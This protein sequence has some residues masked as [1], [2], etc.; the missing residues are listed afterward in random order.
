MKTKITISK[1]LIVFLIFSLLSISSSFA[2]SYPPPGTSC[3]SGDLT[4]VG[5]TLS[6]GDLCNSCPTA[7][8]ITRTLTLSINN[9]TGST[10][11]SFAFWGNLEV[12]SGTTGLLVSNTLITGCNGPL[13]PNTITTLSYNTV[14]YTCGDV[15][16]ITNLYLAWTSASPGSTCPLDPTLISPKCGT[17]PTITV[18]GGV[19]GEFALTDS[20]CGSATGAIDLTPTGGTAPFT[21][22]WTATAGGAVPSGQ[23]NNQDLTGLLPGTY[24]VV[25]T[26]VNGCTITKSRTIGATTPTI[27]TFANTSDITVP[28]GGATTS[29]LSYTNN[30]T[31]SCLISGTVTS[32]LSTQTP[33]GA[34]GGTVT[35][36]WTFTDA[37]GRTITKTRTITISPATL[38]TMTAPAA[39][40]VA[41]GSLPAPT[42]LS[43]TNGLSGGCL[44]NGTSNP[45][46]F[47]TPPGAC[48]GTVTETWTAT[49]S[50]GRA[51]APV[52]RIITVSPAAL[53]TMT[54]PAATT[55]ACGSLPAPSTISFS[56][57]LSGGCLI[58]GNSNPSTFSTTPGACGGT[59]TETW[60]A[61]D[62][63]GRALAPVSR[64]ITVSPATL[65]TM[66]APAA[67][68]VACGS[69]PAPSTISFSNGLSGGCLISGNSNPSTFST[70]PGACGGTVT[71]TWTATDSCGRALAPVS[72]IIT[73]S[74]AALPTMTAPTA[75]TVACGS[76]PAPST[77]SFSNG[78]SGGCLISGTSN[79]STFSTLSS[80]CGGTITETWTATD[81]CG[82]ALAPVSRT[83]TVS[84][85]ALPTMTAPANITVA[86]G[87]I[88]A[89]ST[90]S[91][92]NG[93]S[94]SCAINGTS[95]P[96]TFTATPPTCGGTVTET[97]TATDSCGRTIASVSR[98]ITVSPAALPT[99]N[100]PSGITI[101][102]G[103]TP[104]PSTLSF[105][106]GL[107]GGCAI[108]GTS[109]PSTFTTTVPGFCNGQIVETW[110]ATDSCGRALAPVTR[111]ITVN[112]TTPPTF[113]VP[114][115]I[116][117][118]TDASCNT[119]LDPST[120]GTVTNISD[121]CDTAPTVTYSDN[122][123]FGNDNAGSIN[124]GNGNYFYFDVTGFDNLT[125]KDI[126]KIALAFETN[127]GKGR[128]EFTLVAPNGTAVILVGPYCTGGACEDAN[129][130]DQELYLPT[131][132]PNSSGYP[133]WNNNDVI[134]QDIPQ[135]FTPNGAL[136]SP[137]SITGLTSYV[138]SFENLTGP[139]NG[140]WFIFS[141]K[142]A[143]VNG[144]IN[145]NSVCLTPLNV[146][147]NNRVITRTWTVTDA[148]GNSSTANQTISIQDVT[149]PT[150]T[151]VAGS[152]DAT[153]E[154]SDAAALAS[155]QA[156]FPTATDNCDTDVTNIVKT[157]GAFVASQTCANA[158]T[159]TNTW[160][161]TD[162]CGNTSQV[163]TQTITVRDT[164]PPTWT[165]VAGTLDATI[166]CSNAAALANAQA[167]APSATDNCD[168]NV[169]YIKTSG[170]FVP[171][172]CAG[173]GSY[174]NTWVA[175]DACLNTS[176][177]FTQ[178][179][180]VQDTTA[181]TISIAAA[182][183]TVECDGL[184]NT[185]ALAAW[186]ASNGGA[187][188]SD[189]C[190]SVTWT[191]N[192]S[193]LSD[194]CGNSGSALVTFTAT[195]DCGNATTTSAT[196]T[197]QDDTAPTIN[198]QATN[199]TVE[200]DGNG[201]SAAL[202]AWLASNG[203]ASASDICSNVTWTNNFTTL[204]NGCGNS[205]SAL[206]TFTATD[207]CGN[208]TSSTATFTIRDTTAP[209]IS[210]AA[211]DATVECDGNGNSAALTAWLASNGGASA[212][213]ICSNVTW[214]NN[215]SAFTDSCG[216][217]GSASVTF[218]A[219]DDCGN[220]T[221]TSATFTIQDT[222]A[223][224]I[225]IAATDA[226][227]ECDGQGNTAALAEWLASNGG[228]S[229]SDA[230]SNVTWSNNFSAFTDG[231]GNSG[232][233]LV[234]FTA[235][236]DCGN[237]TTTSATFTI[238]DTTAPT[239]TIAA[240]DATVECDGQGNT[241]TLAEWLASNGGASASDICSNVTWSNNFSAFTD[242][243]GNSGSALV[244]FTAT[245]DCGN[246]TTTS[247]TFTIQD[248]TAP[249]ITIAATDATVECDGQGNTA[250]LA[251]WLASNGGASASDA[252]SNVIWT[253]NFSAFTDGCGNSGSALVTFT[254]TDDCGN[255]S[256]TSA[257]F[258]IQD[259]T[260][261]T[262]T[263]AA[264]D[265]TVEC[266][267][268]GNTAALE[269]W[270]SSNGGASAS[271]ACS[272]VIWT[273]NFSAFT[274]GCGNSGSA[275]V[276]FTATDD[277]G[278]ATT[279]S[280]TFTIQDTTAPTITI[281][282]TDATV[283]CDGQGNTAALEA[284]LSSNGGASAS[285]VCSNVT[286][287][288]NF[289]ALTDGC[290]NSG[291]ASV[292]FT[293]TDDCGNAVTSTATFTIQD[294]T[295]PTINIA[296]TDLAV[297]CDGSGG[298]STALAAWLASN[299]GASASDTCSNVTWTNNFGTIASDCS[300]AITVIFTAT[301]DCGNASTT[302][303]TFTVQDNIAPT[304]DIVAANATVECDGN[305]NSE[306]LAA[307]LASNGGAS[308][309]D[310]CS[311]VTW[312][313]NFTTFTDG[314][315]NSGSATVTFTA[316]DTCGN[317]ATTSATFTIQDTTAPTITIAAANAT[318]ECDGN[319]NT[320][321]LATWLASN[322]GASA[323]DTCSNVI[324]SNNFNG[325]SNGCGNTGSATVTFTATDDCGNA[326]TTSATFT[327]EDTTAPTI[328]IAAADA[329]VECDGNG[330]PEALV[331][332]LASNGGASA[333][334]TC[335]N[336]TWT[337]NFEEL[338]D[339]CGSTGSATV[340][341]TA[342]DD[343]GNTATSTAT[344][345]IQDTTAPIITIAAANATAECD[346]NGNSTALAAWLASNGGASATD[347]CSNVTWT[348]NFDGLSDGCGN[349]GSA[350]VTFTATDDCGN[351]ATTS[352]T[353][354]IEDTTA[355]TITIAAVNASAECDGN[356][357]AE[358]LAAWLASN[359][360]ASATD[361]C[362]NV[363]WTNNFDGLSDGCGN[364]GS[365]T[366][367]FTATD[368]CGNTATTS[369]TFTIEDT[370]APTITIAATNATAE[371]D[372]NGNAE[373]LAAWLASNG[374]ASATD[375]C[376]NVTWTNSF[377][378]LSDGC[379]NTG[380]ATVTFT[381]TDDCGNTATTSATFT[382]EDTTAPT[383]T[384]VATDATVE[385]DGN[386]NA[387]ALA[388]W[389]ASNGGASATDTCSNVTWTNNFSTF[390]DGCGNAGSA[391]VT[392]TAA[393]DCGNI[394]TSTATFTIQDTTAPTI[395][396]VATDATV[397]CDGNGNAEA[398]AAWLASNGGAS[399][400][401]SCSNVT[402]TN[403]FDGLSDGCGNT[404]SATVTFTATDDCGNSVTSTAT[405]T[406]QDTTAPT[407][408][409]A[410]TDATAECDGNG[411]T[412]ALAAWLA[413]NGGASASDACSNVTWTNNYEAL[414]DGCGS[415]GSATVT[416]TAT[417]DCGNSTSSTATFAIQDTTPPT[418][419]VTTVN[420]TV[421]CDGSGN[422][423]AL[424]AWLASN[425]GASAIDICSNV[426]WTNSFDGLSDGCG[427]TGSASV[428]FT[429][430]DDCGNSA[431][432]TGTFTIVDT[433]APT[434]T[435][436]AANSTVECD[437][438][439]NTAALNAWLASNGGATASDACSNVTWSNNFIALSDDCGSTGSATVIFTAT[440]GCGNSV[441]S[442]AT[443]TIQDTTAP[444]LTTEFD[445]KL[446]VT[447]AAI[448]DAPILVFTDNCSGN[449]TPV[450]N[451][452]QSPTVDNVYTIIR[453]WIA[454]DACG[455][456]SQTYTQ[457]IYVTVTNTT[458]LEIP[459]ERCNLAEFDSVDLVTLL[460]QGL[461]T[462][463]TWTNV[464]SATGLTGTVFNPFGVAIGDYIFRYT[465]A[466]GDCFDSYDIVMNVND[467]CRPLPCE[468]IVIHNAFTPNGDNI[469]EWFQIDNIEDFDCYPSN[470]VEIYNRWGVLVYETNNYDNLG[471]RFEGISE[472]RTTINKSEELP[473]GT[474]FYIIQWTTTDGTSVTKDGYLYLTR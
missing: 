442:T 418:I 93:L 325:L 169:T 399:A 86:C 143:S 192:F 47:S 275:S 439:G 473:T 303:A 156:L 41:C 61:T 316:T 26:D 46:T 441:T 87:S 271:D 95:N 270:L 110:T 451:Q 331:A 406:I 73:V 101:S 240:T 363:T 380:S 422:A 277:C 206:V 102:C 170:D 250:A 133:Q 265:A 10:R 43:F 416:F 32:T 111:T 260:A 320:E 140:T 207:D 197:I 77:I 56:N 279:T 248:T 35:E 91:F 120:T 354:T 7:T 99:M 346:G 315:G 57:G 264:T 213:D 146:C 407:I 446:Q 383:I 359:G 330:N 84:P 369:A 114:G 65:P 37:L 424:A 97:W 384:S 42:T 58:S 313:N 469:N 92:T 113:T 376:S 59:V 138:S 230:C 82:R 68:T 433:T 430:T 94:G 200:C 23:Q 228:A 438:Q 125:A 62:S 60:T 289:N 1:K 208:N 154:C 44:I 33:A 45:S 11:T 413:S 128:A 388:A 405:F 449:V 262:I 393:D 281:A 245:D 103:V 151:T 81:S 21:Y 148:C 28:C 204:S 318:A 131:F 340:T 116:T 29:S 236:D 191:N 341:F 332:W 227:V 453:T 324:W 472:G 326:T 63:C 272:N 386:G 408:D 251:E 201:N 71:E 283:E 210:T 69:L 431:S 157:S 16:K 411:N 389:L 254:A 155:A 466:N 6:G 456:N 427:S 322:G 107:A 268:Q 436:P 377:D 462:D 39:T 196:F 397:E 288:N 459:A 235:T 351:T 237:A 109:N 392:F 391:T 311:N 302:S 452:T 409:I 297:Q 50:C 203:G 286:W 130:S 198:T 89:P 457:R 278:N 53:P 225:T 444:V 267:G 164:T 403:S 423:E 420:V 142:Q 305:G 293:A 167:L 52:S 372:G 144:S 141:R 287:T 209:T 461:P 252:C 115:P 214:S 378:G 12:Y 381:A 173:S 229:A 434:L 319:G 282:A 20:Q 105:S 348:N 108:T 174:T 295:A 177:T 223:P 440:D 414:S 357:N 176:T 468:L 307:W 186:L 135:N 306:A 127:Q 401:D 371:C 55:V 104:T 329:T 398:L 64:T 312:T 22:V 455:N 395:D 419:S 9:T 412:E 181:P 15:L 187:S 19:N 370:T 137:N 356:G 85:A 54:A 218:T 66:T 432:A 70:T 361:T 149:A 160:T 202:T 263:I 3:T 31:G 159:Y 425:G 373:A 88:P 217:S 255:A 362:S 464:D 166:E 463:G 48:G 310:T 239:I 79:P 98:T 465:I 126:Q 76:L 308:A 443:F 4:L 387:E 448:P 269:A 396:I 337:N 364:T 358:A 161:V 195:D 339:S 233:A 284:W 256:T 374:G 470:K 241:A 471:R 454:T 150:W 152:L 182:N 323:S 129:S 132:Y 450:L 67:T 300:T 162:A 274:D 83:I 24:T 258:T 17:L 447:C 119:N 343:C 90:I 345:T 347:T 266:D 249:T 211:A 75:I 212:S 78:L 183:A 72:R 334:D 460:P 25:I 296:A 467:D 2:Q 221:T 36:T 253:N 333:S 314:C 349:T 360:G 215:F 301:D 273:N 194:G 402:W 336:V 106:N 158:G 394:A 30:G 74:P 238:Q 38:P 184:G 290:G 13:P 298:T 353:F 415:T 445:Q 246:A 247:A 335:S 199:A 437:G 280:A 338:N 179:I 122:E 231:C 234:T 175:K 321:A 134:T 292:T 145:F 379:G 355:P 259:T 243:C 49:D 242:G 18:N 382:I 400:S 366:V 350:T 112:D 385:C 458:I 390:S 224:T 222:T 421:E 435:A 368:D 180:T 428:T 257:T 365:A 27:A 299:G 51:L 5:A 309:T 244:T 189:A 178:T 304:I 232:S 327:I 121:N 317:T 190:S 429:A 168:N 294:T 153:V 171:G 117:A 40:T 410:A 118:N 136:S 276:T 291:S 219:T 426:T 139:M 342:T 367:T 172:A 8:T 375:T 163:F 417:D 193:A 352:A 404:G 96:S 34:C 344:F 328:T 124:A 80:A 205:G 285:D 123:C 261:P 474:Y 226:T 147:S 165:T 216:N 100:A 220:A 14:T 185:G 188:A